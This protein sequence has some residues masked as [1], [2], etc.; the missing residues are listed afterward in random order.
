MV[1]H[2]S[3]LIYFEIPRGS[4]LLLVHAASQL[5]LAFARTLGV[6]WRERRE[7]E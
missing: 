6:V 7:G 1:K 5:V 2:Q 4:Y 3:S